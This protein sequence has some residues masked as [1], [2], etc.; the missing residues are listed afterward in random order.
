M[1]FILLLFLQRHGL[2]HSNMSKNPLSLTTAEKKLLIVF[3]YYIILQVVAFIHFSLT[4][5]ASEVIQGEF[6]RYFLC[7]QNGD[8]PDNRCSRSGF[9]N[10]INPVVAI[11]SFTLSLLATVVNFVFVISYRDLKQKLKSTFRGKS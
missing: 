11:L 1:Y 2:F 8:D 9:E 3:C 6:F 10:L 7:E 5:Q 4:R